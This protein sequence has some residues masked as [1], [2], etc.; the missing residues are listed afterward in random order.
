[1]K[2][3]ATDVN[4]YCQNNFTVVCDLIYRVCEFSALRS[5]EKLRISVANET[6]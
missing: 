3:T 4:L 1:M 2:Y 6:P 5:K